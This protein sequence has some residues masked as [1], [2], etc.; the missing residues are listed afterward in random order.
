MRKLTHIEVVKRVSELLHTLIIIS[1]YEGRF[2]KILVKDELNIIYNVTPDKLFAGKKP[3]LATAIN[4]TE[5]FIIKARKI[6]GDKYNYTN[7]NYQKDNIKIKIICPLHGEFEQLPTNHLTGQGCYKCGI[8]NMKQ[9]RAENG[10]SRTQWINYCNKNNKNP[11]LYILHCH[12][13]IESFIKVGITTR[14]V[15]Q[16]NGNGRYWKTNMPYNHSVLLEINGTPEWCFDIEKKIEHKYN[17]FKYKPQLYFNGLTECYSLE[18]LN[19]ANGK[20]VIS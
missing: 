4:K 15:L 2:K 14:N 3:S 7:I 13:K 9:N 5:G 17:C 10:F 16:S 20:G 1:K 19:N 18:L 12:N 6:H 8:E 11:K